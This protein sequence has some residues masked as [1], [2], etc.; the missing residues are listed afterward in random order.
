MRISRATADHVAVWYGHA[1][2]MNRLGMS[3]FSDLFPAISHRFVETV[4]V[5]IILF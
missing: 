4:A 3:L 2:G 1:R 5:Q